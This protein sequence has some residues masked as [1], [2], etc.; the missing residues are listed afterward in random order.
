M[1][2]KEQ[3]K[4]FYEELANGDKV[5]NLPVT[6][7][8]NVEGLGRS[9]NTYYSVGN[10]VYVD[11]NLSVALKCTTAGT[12]SNTELDISGRAVGESV[13]DGSVVWEVVSRDLSD[14]LSE[15]E[16][17][18]MPVGTIIAYAGNTP[19]I[20]FLAC[21]G[22]SL[23]PNTYVN[24][25]NI[26]GTTYGGDGS[27]TFNLPNLN[28]NSFLEGS[29]TAGTVKSA[30]LPNITG[31]IYHVAHLLNITGSADGAF[32]RTGDA[33][34]KGNASGSGNGND[35]NF[36]ASRCSPVYGNSDTVQ[37]KSVTVIYCI[38]Y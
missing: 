37:P 9:A 29:D 18:L 20:N 1:A 19:P 2:I 35:Y 27:T 3:D 21:N 23:N 22:A 7:A 5:I 16:T 31:N 10:V 30:G 32:V 33:T 24:L 8:N 14:R 12:T 4:V 36:D 11:S 34:N 17:Y 25:F 6:R 26:I 15:A 28:N 13:E 38:K